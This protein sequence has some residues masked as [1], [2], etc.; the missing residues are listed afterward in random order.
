MKKIIKIVSLLVVFTVITAV[1]AEFKLSGLR[2]KSEDADGDP[3]DLSTEK[4][5]YSAFAVNTALISTSSVGVSARSCILCTSDGMVLYEK[6]AD[7]PLPMA[8][9]TKVM[10]VIVALE[11][12]EDVAAVIEVSPLAV[13]IEGSSVYLQAGEKVDYEMLLYSAMLESANDATTALAIAVSGSE[14]DFVAEMNKKADELGMKSTEFKNPHGLS[15]DGHY[16]TA[17]DYS[18]LMAY[19]LK[20]DTF[21]QIIS[22]RKKVIMSADGS[23]TRVLTNHNRLL[24]TYKGMI[25]GKTGYTQASGRTLVTAAQRNGTTLI[26]V[27]IDASGDWN[28]HTMLFDRGFQTV[29]TEVLTSENC[30]TELPVAAGIKESVTL[31]LK[32]DFPV[33]IPVDSEVTVDYVYPHMRFAPVKKG[34]SFGYAVYYIDGKKAGELPLYADED[35]PGIE[36]EIKSGII[37]KIKGFFRKEGK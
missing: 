3:T 15:A 30:R 20:N 21:R 6:Q 35:I 31:T 13:G 37:E 23:L 32:D 12:I 22:T 24:I 33:T 14:E 27:T 9:I 36:P 29:R 34:D 2:G 18:R 26:C 10:S 8:S 16:T 4:T 25:G 17:R 5:D 11:K 1:L 28:D 7:V 19:A